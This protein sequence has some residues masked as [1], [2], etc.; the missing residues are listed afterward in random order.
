LVF[1]GIATLIERNTPPEGFLVEW[2]LG[3]EEQKLFP[4]FNL[5]TLLVLVLE[6]FFFSL[7]LGWRRPN[8]ITGLSGITQHRTPP[9]EM[10]FL[11]NKAADTDRKWSRELENVGCFESRVFIKN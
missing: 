6:T 2:F 1:A 5:L 3:P 10:G 7:F 11:S 9:R 8:L 4:N